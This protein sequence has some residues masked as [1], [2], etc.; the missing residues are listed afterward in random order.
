MDYRPIPE[1]DERAFFDMMQYAF[2]PEDH[3]TAESFE[4]RR[5][6]TH[7]LR[8]Y[9]D[10][11]DLFAA[12][13]WHDFT[14]SLRGEWVRVGGVSNVATPPEHR[15]KGYVQQMLAAMLT[16][17]R[18]EGI[19][20]SVLWPFEYEFYRKYGWGTC[21]KR[22]KWEFAPDALADALPE[23]AG[24]FRKLSTDDIPALRDL[25]EQFAAGWNLAMRRTEE[26]W[27]RRIFDPPWSDT[28]IYGWE[29]DGDLRAAV[30]YTVEKTGEFER[31]LKAWDIAYRDDAAFTQLLRFFY[32][33][34]SQMKQ[35]ELHIAAD[36]TLFDRVADPRALDCELLTGPM[37]RLTDVEAGLSRLP[38]PEAASGRVVLDVR[39]PIA[40]WNDGRFAFSVENGNATCTPTTDDATVS[41]DIATL[42]QLTVGYLTAEQ[43][44]RYGGLSTDSDAALELLSGAFPRAQTYL[45]EHF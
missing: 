27:E 17:F 43:A 19:D 20:Y 12:S 31:T 34:L 2:S 24:T 41:V 16:E 40:P 42:S 22:T 7:E 23:A 32:H 1:A 30:V 26:W 33:H 36:S 29:H 5:P 38:Y 44:H 28:Y 37:F 14:F 45:R 25:T 10:G 6:F 18:A 4:E 8:G 21:N 39:D 15:R 9:Y 13:A 11:D 3:P 35:I